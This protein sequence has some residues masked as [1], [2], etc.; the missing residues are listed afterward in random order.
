MKK[1]FLITGCAGFIGFNLTLKLLNQ[2]NKY[3]LYGIDNLNEYYDPNL[4]ADRLKELKKFDNF[5][6]TKLSLEN[7]NSLKTLLENHNFD[8]II[9]FRSSWS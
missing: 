5:N 9:H 6:F 4:K 8:I 2:N 3:E 1:K 7:F